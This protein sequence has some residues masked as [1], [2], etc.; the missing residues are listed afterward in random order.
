MPNRILRE[1][2]LP[3]LESL[4]TVKQLL[5]VRAMLPRLTAGDPLQS[6]RFRLSQRLRKVRIAAVGKLD[7][8]VERSLYAAAPPF[9]PVCT[10]LMLVWATRLFPTID[11]IKPIAL[12]GTNEP[13]NL[14]VICNSC[15]SRK[16]ARA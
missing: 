3:K 11:H 2:Q 16:G 7:K 1:D 13:G 8:K 14:R 6:Y 9:C 5:D 4:S 12:G 10:R 15:N